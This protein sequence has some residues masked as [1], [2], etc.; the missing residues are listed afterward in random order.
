MSERASPESDTLRDDAAN[1]VARV[2]GQPIAQT[3]KINSGVMTFKYAVQTALG[4]IF[5]ARF[6]P[7]ERALVVKY[8]PDVI[9]RCNLHGL[10]VA[11]LVADSRDGPVA[12]L[13]Y[14][15]YRMIPGAA[16]E[17]RIASLS[18]G[19]IERICRALVE[20]MLLLSE[21]EVIGF[22]DLEGGERARFASWRSF[23]EQAFADALVQNNVPPAL[24]YA[25]ERIRD[26]L[27]R[28][29]FGGSASFAWSDISP[30]N[31]IL[32]AN[33]EFAGFVDLESVLAAEPLLA[34]GYFRARYDGTRFFAILSSSWPKFARCEGARAALYGL[35]R[36]L[37]LLPHAY[38]A[39]PTGEPR[40]RLES[41]LPGLHNALDELLRSRGP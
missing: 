41:F 40:D 7:P 5:I 37:R 36:A 30:G 39:L 19:T 33:D 15:I 35:I 11:D 6:Y 21:I 27:D 4:E 16:M 10:K 18:A 31:I 29:A 8:E 3:T 2:T 17:T 34:Y 28:F 25:V 38:R 32:D 23:V 1:I 13:E 24:R 26:G 20:Q 12:T 14:M 22:G 9:R